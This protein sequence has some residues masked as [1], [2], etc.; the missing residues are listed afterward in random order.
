MKDCF[1]QWE[2]WRCSGVR[3][4]AFQTRTLRQDGDRY[5]KKRPKKSFKISSLPKVCQRGSLSPYSSLPC[6]IYISPKGK[7]FN[8]ILEVKA[9]FHNAHLAGDMDLY[10]VKMVAWLLFVCFFVLLLSCFLFLT[11]THGKNIFNSGEH[12]PQKLQRHQ[13][14]S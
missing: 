4:V 13:N 9:F 7:T 3:S 10:V 5:K 12:V 14:K 8:N 11:M 1:S 2:G 6:T